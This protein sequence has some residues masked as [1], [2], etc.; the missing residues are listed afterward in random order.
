VGVHHP[1]R[2]G[3]RHP[4]D[5]VTQ[6]PVIDQGENCGGGRHSSTV[7]KRVPTAPGGAAD[8]WMDRQLC[9]I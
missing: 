9:M 4:V 6:R 2:G 8:L 3:G 1:H 5:V 7:Q